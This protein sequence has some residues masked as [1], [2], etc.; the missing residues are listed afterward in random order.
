VML[1][2]FDEVRAGKRIVS[3]TSYALPALLRELG[4]DVRVLPLV[5]DTLDDVTRATLDA[6]EGG[7][8]G[9]PD[10]LVTTGGISVGEHDY[11]RDALLSLGGKLDFWR[12][13]IR[14]GGPI[15][16]GSVRSVRWLG[17][18]GNPVSSMVTAMLFAGPL[19]RRLGG[20]S[21]TQHAT[22]RVRMLD[23]V[24]TAAPLAHFLR[25]ALSAGPDGTIEARM[26]GAQG[27][28]LL[29]TMALAD[30]L[31]HVPHDVS[32]VEAGQ[33]YDAIPFP[34]ALWCMPAGLAG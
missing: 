1:D 9:P 4:A 33:T 34:N 22:I 14:P 28:N 11:T 19:L 3:S 5:S 2:R 23:D 6:L 20:H 10:V 24:A 21:R 17:L 13:R 27:S 16:S 18:P 29:R 8:D 30:A 32:R 15:G 12:A 31:L 25:V 7:A 26:T